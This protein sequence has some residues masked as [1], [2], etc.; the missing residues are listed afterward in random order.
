MYR[1]RLGPKIQETKTYGPIKIASLES[2]RYE[3]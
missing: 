3:H 1:D 2:I